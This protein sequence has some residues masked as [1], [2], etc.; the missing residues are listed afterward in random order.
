MR[1]PERP[2][3]G[4]RRA[5]LAAALV[6][7]AMA[8]PARPVE[9]WWQ[10]AWPYR[11]QIR[12]D[13]TPQGADIQEDLRDVPVLIRLHPGNLDFTR[14]RNDGQDIRFVGPDD[15]TLLPHHTEV[16]DPIDEVGLLWVQVPQIAGGRNQ[17]FLW[18]YYGNPD[19]AGGQNVKGTYDPQHAAVFHLDEAEGPPRDASPAG[20][21]AAAFSGALGFP[22]AVGNGAILTGPGDGMTLSAS[23]SLEFPGGFTFSAWFRVTG[24]QSDAYLFSREQ[25]E[26]VLAVGID[27]AHGFV[28]V[29]GEGSITQEAPDPEE[30]SLDAWHHLQVSAEAGGRVAFILDG[31]ERFVLDVEGGLPAPAGNVTIGGSADGG[32]A[33]AGD[34]D[35]V[36]IAGVPRTA[37]WARAAFRGQ[38]PD[39]ALLTVGEEE[40]CEGG[41]LPVFYL[42]TVLKNITLDGWLIIGLLV[43]L[44]AMSWFVFVGKAVFL[45]V[46]DR[47]NRSSLAVFSRQQAFVPAGNDAGTAYPNATMYGVYRAGMES[48][49]TSAA[50][51]GGTAPARFLTPR[52]AA[53]FKAAL[54]EGFTR[55][56]QR[57]HSRLVVLTLAIAGGPFLGL[58]G[59]VWG[60][61]N[62]FAAMAEAGE[63]NIMA[64]AP[65]VASALATTVVGLIVA[66]PA[67]FAYNYLTTRIRNLTLDTSLFLDRFA[68]KV[69]EIHGGGG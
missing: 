18:M 56:N 63:A 32:H 62:T 1:H 58:L 12:F 28:R 61:M 21:H 26:Q 40:A 48:L 4:M 29:R 30:I 52:G 27:R 69:E 22:S 43:V 47:E 15:R 9:A 11:K 49:E 7:C 20:N 31:E 66:I 36:Q 64:I 57:M 59:T 8:L 51:A 39:G 68:L 34:L 17:D 6:I 23:P 33:F 13:T 5:S 42:A 55:E 19:A 25:G 24:P 35:E 14:V 60:V 67:L 53:A 45:W 46:T 38:G 54:E 50:A 44:S 65:G 2:W 3:P 37:G 41:G 16:F 10:D